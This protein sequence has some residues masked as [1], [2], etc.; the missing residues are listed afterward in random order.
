MRPRV[1]AILLLAVVLLVAAGLLVAGPAHLGLHAD[2]DGPGCDACALHGTT[3]PVFEHGLGDLG[4]AWIEPELAPPQAP[5]TT[6][7]LLP[8]PRGP[9]GPA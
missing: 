5:A 9:P 7:R 8:P 4:V 6:T 2:A 1:R 3:P